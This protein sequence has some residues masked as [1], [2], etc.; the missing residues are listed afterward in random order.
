MKRE[1]IRR[2]KIIWEGKYKEW[3]INKEKNDKR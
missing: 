2:E 3:K 1:N